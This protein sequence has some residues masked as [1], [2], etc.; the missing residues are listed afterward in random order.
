MLKDRL[1]LFR[2]ARGFSMDALAEATGGKVSKQAISKYENGKMKPGP[3][4]IVSIARALDIKAARLL[5]EP[6]VY[7]EPIAYRKKSK[8]GVKEMSRVK[9]LMQLRMEVAMKIRAFGDCEME[10]NHILPRR[11]F[12]SVEEAEDAALEI[13][14]SWGLGKDPI[15][16]V[17]DALEQNGITVLFLEGDKGKNFDGLSAWVKN[18]EDEAIGAVIAVRTG[19]S[20]ARQRMNL[21]HE[22]GHLVQLPQSSCDEEKLAFRFAGAFLAPKPLVLSDWGKTQRS[23][24]LDELILLKKR[25]GMSLQAIARRLFDLELIS[26][27]TYTSL[28]IE[29]NR[30]GY[31]TWEPL[32]DEMEPERST[33][34]PLHALRALRYGVISSEEYRLFVGDKE[35]A[36]IEPER[37]IPESPAD[38]K[39]GKE[40]GDGDIEVLND[41]YSCEESR[42]WE[43]TNVASTKTTHSKK[44]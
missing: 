39:A 2:V 9:S 41:F 13:R 42:L 4:K 35:P 23:A 36:G 16:N 3:S 26:R 27:T 5:A 40:L 11:L 29:I 22:L 44:R 43:E 1:R 10:S 25:Y 30:A 15:P 7:V 32:D 28:N 31:K 8:L 18:E 6:Q 12:S 14:S 17:L 24:S 37:A 20:G 33:L 19:I 34:L 21:A 38:R